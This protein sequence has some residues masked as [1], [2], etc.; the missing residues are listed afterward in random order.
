MTA[1]ARR[2]DPT[3]RTSDRPMAFSTEEFMN[4]GLWTWALFCGLVPVGILASMLWSLPSSAG[5]SWTADDLQVIGFLIMFSGLTAVVALVL[6]PVGL[7]LTWPFARLLVRVRSIPIHVVIYTLLGAAIG[8]LY[9]AVSGGLGALGVVNTY[10][11]LATT[12]AVAI[13]FAVP[14]GWW[15]TARRA[16]RKDAGLL[17]PRADVDAI[18]EDAA[19]APP[20]C[21]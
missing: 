8:L 10:T 14:L 17:R 5:W 21:V 9:L 1:P 16:L 3:V 4:G 15:L 11:I 7:V 12:P 2:P 19:T 6:M 18:I 13:T 20:G